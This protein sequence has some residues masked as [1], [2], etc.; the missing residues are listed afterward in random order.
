MGF[1]GMM[2]WGALVLGWVAEHFGT[3]RAV[4]MGGI[5]CISAALFAWHD[6]KGESWRLK[7]AE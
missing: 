7:A 1:L 4:T 2:P 3:G 6:R 5:I